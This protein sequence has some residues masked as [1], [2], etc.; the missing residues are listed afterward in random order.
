MHPELFADQK[1][2]CRIAEA[3]LQ[4]GFLNRTEKG[5][6]NCILNLPQ[7]REEMSFKNSIYDTWMKVPAK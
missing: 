3:D 6:G 5:M 7:I 1:E 2:E 4:T